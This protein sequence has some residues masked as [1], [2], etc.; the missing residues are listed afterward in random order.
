[1]SAFL[2]CDVLNFAK[3]VF[4][5]DNDRHVSLAVDGKKLLVVPEN[6]LFLFGALKVLPDETIEDH[7][8]QLFGV[9]KNACEVVPFVGGADEKHFIRSRTQIGDVLFFAFDPCAFGLTSLRCRVRTRHDEIKNVFAKVFFDDR[10]VLG[11]AVFHNIVQ[12]RRNELVF[13]ASSNGYLSGYGHGMAD[14]WNVGGFALLLFVYESGE[15]KGGADTGRGVHGVFCLR[16][17]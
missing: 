5:F 1:M 12:Q 14:V 8:A 2:A 7:F 4:E 13:R 3:Q 10:H 11:A 17:S 16:C 15:S 9:G 6:H